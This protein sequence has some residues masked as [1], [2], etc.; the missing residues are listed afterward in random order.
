MPDNLTNEAFIN[1]GYN[2]ITA[3]DTVRDWLY[4]NIEP[5]THVNEYGRWRDPVYTTWNQLFN[6][7]IT[8][9]SNDI[10]EDDLEEENELLDE[11][12]NEFAVKG[13]DNK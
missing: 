2:A 7:V 9:D 1:I 12:L 11:F 3:T 8:E 10:R 13:D 6:I 5:D 4:T